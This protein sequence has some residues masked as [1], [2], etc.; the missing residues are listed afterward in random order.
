MSDEL[1]TQSENSP[2]PGDIVDAVELWASETPQQQSASLSLVKLEA[3]ETLIVPFTTMTVR[4]A[5]H[6]LK[7]EQLSGYVQCPGDGCL[8]CRLLDN[9]P[10]LR[11]LLPVYEP[12]ARAIGVLA[13]TQNLRAM[14]LRPQL[15][16]LLRR[17]KAGERLLIGLRKMDQFGSRFAVTVTPLPEGADDGAEQIAAFKQQ[18]EAGA[19]DLRTVYQRLQAEE[20]AAIPEIATRMSLKGV[21]LP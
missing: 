20:L 16:P 18:M 2:K 12:V 14:T 21:K 7:S 3:N 13:I 17:V 8:L 11:D 19:I 10:E 1:R 15:L 9:E 5:V 4:Q 6:Y